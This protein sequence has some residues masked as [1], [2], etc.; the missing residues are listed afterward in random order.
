VRDGEHSK[1]FTTAEVLMR[2]GSFFW[3]VIIRDKKC[4][5]S[6]HL[7]TVI[8]DKCHLVWGWCE[9]SQDYLSLGAI[10][11]DFKHH[12]FIVLSAT[13]IPNVFNF[14]INSVVLRP[15]LHPYTAAIDKQNITQIVAQIDPAQGYAQL[16]AL[17]TI[18]SGA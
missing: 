2:D 8:M 10:R 16:S 1:V 4:A 14:I 17:I 15:C 5:S 6:E 9:F 18:S 13:I 11:T 3:E 7:H 12:P